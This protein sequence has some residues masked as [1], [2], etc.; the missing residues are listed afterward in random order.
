MMS[1]CALRQ[2]PVGLALVAGAA[3]VSFEHQRFDL[4]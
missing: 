3:L 4:I 1:P 2:A